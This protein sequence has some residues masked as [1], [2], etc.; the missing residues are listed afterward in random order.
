MPF[1]LLYAQ[2]LFV[3]LFI[4][5]EVIR[6]FRRRAY[7]ELIVAGSIMLLALAYGIDFITGSQFLPNPNRLL[8]L[9]RPISESFE[10]FFQVME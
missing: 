4:S 10:K 3:I 7:K 2:V 5:L 9:L 8:I 1:R 6:L